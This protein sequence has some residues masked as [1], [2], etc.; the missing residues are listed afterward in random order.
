MRHKMRPALNAVGLQL[1]GKGPRSQ[2]LAC[3]ILCVGMTPVHLLRQRLWLQ[4]YVMGCIA[5]FRSTRHD[6]HA[7]GKWVLEIPTPRQPFDWCGADAT[8]TLFV[9]LLLCP[10]AVWVGTHQASLL[11]KAALSP[12]ILIPHVT[13]S[14]IVLPSISP[15]LHLCTA[16]CYRRSWSLLLKGMC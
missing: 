11:C 3:K 13:T 12:F 5:G 8:V 4:V 2:R 9:C 1:T 15:L 14:T 16:C 10:T 7:Q 6:H